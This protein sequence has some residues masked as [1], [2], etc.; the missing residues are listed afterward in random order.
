MLTAVSC[1][2]GD[3]IPNDWKIGHISVIHKK[4]KK[5]EYENYREITVLNIF[6]RLYG[7]IIKHFFE[8]EF[9]QIETEEQAVFRVGRSTIDHIF[10]LRHLIEKKMAVN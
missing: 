10:C 9:Y 4:G 8:Q 7:K 5:D 2:N 6:S 3:E 1:L